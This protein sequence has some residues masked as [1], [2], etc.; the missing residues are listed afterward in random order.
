MWG[1]EHG[2]WWP[3]F[4]IIVIGMIICALSS[5][6]VNQHKSIRYMQTPVP[7]LFWVIKWGLI[8]VVFLY[9]IV[10]LVIGVIYA[11][12]HID[13]TGPFFIGA[14]VFTLLIGLGICFFNKDK[15]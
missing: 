3:A 13:R 14:I 12:G 15:L 5:M 7:L 8:L 1:T 11:I 9:A 2:Y 4:G 10:A 6:N